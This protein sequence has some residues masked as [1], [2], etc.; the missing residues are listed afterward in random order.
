VPQGVQQQAAGHAQS[1]DRVSPS[2]YVGRGGKVLDQCMREWLMAEPDNTD[3]PAGRGRGV[4]YASC[5]PL[6]VVTAG[7]TVYRLVQTGVP[8]WL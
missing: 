8:A 1:R 2:R 4:W 5:L 7:Q 3:Q 6:C